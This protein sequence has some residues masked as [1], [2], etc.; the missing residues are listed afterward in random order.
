MLERRLNGN[1]DHDIKVVIVDHSSS[2]RMYDHCLCEALAAQGCDVLFL[3]NDYP[4][5]ELNYQ[6]SYET[7]D[8]FYGFTNRI[9]RKWKLAS[10]FRK[11]IRAVEYI[12]NMVSLVRSI[13][14]LKPDV[15]HF[16]TLP[17]P[18]ID[19]LFLPSLKKIGK[20]VVTAHDTSSRK[21]S[22][23]QFWGFFRCLRKFDHIISLTSFSK[24][25]V[26]AKTGIPENMITIIPH[27]VFDSYRTLVQREPKVIKN[28]DEKVIL[29]FG[30]I[31]WYKGLDVL[32]KALSKLPD[33]LFQQSRL[34]V[35]GV[36]NIDIQ[37]LQQLAVKLGVDGRI[38]WD[39][40]YIP[41]E[42]VAGLFGQ[43]TVVA[44]PYREIDQSGALHIAIGFGKPIVATAVGGTPEILS[45]GVQGFLVPPD[46]PDAL[47][48]A[49]ARILGDDDLAV[50]MS[51]AVRRLAK[52][53][54]WEVISKQTIDVYKD[55]CSV[56][57]AKLGVH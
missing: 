53:K 10:R 23:I 15:I 29:A 12:F 41:D 38:S 45:D 57:R 24:Q 30:T 3:S 16:E 39:L 52:S 22:P 55:L 33:K 11:P 43:A 42:E 48:V 27:G 21:D 31:E 7:R 40:R 5:G 8:H 34:V 25:R 14:R 56:P 36:P 50:E 44:F 17:L 46:D 37:R 9:L 19:I 26:I 35:A 1:R 18:L 2:V 4:A 13:R 51:A 6:K 47:S 54:S 20:V 32:I 49:L 28:G